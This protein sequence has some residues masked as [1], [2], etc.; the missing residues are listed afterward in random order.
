MI[1]LEKL[2]LRNLF[3]Y[4]FVSFALIMSGVL[5]VFVFN[6]NLFLCLDKIK[7][8]L[9][10]AAITTPLFVV[11][12]L[13]TMVGLTFDDNETQ[14]DRFFVFLLTSSLFT[15]LIVCIIVFSRIFIQ[16][17]TKTVAVVLAILELVLFI[18][19]LFGKKGNN[20]PKKS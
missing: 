19:A 9:L 15:S 1:D 20:K 5:F 2:T 8:I 7:L 11:N 12:I 14:E 13:V 18:S 16:F 6:R 4:L 10:S 3:L 17:N